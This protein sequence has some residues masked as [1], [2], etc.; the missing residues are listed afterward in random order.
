MNISIDVIRSL[1]KTFET[2]L[3]SEGEIF[4]KGSNARIF[5]RGESY[6]L[7]R[8]STTSY[9]GHT[10]LKKLDNLKQIGDVW[11]R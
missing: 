10:G 11:K 9:R 5:S 3:Y 4:F 8:Y 1:A 6:R 2:P 7:L